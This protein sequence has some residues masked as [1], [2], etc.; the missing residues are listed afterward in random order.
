MGA[1]RT[2][3]R[4]ASCGVWAAMVIEVKEGIEAAFVEKGGVAVG[5]VVICVGHRGVGSY[6]QINHS[7]NKINGE[8]V[9]LG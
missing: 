2:Y 1:L 5:R 9:M 4:H 7:K 3:D 8:C 6:Y